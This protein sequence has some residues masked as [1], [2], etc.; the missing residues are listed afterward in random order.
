M[1]VVQ[2]E[3]LLTDFQPAKTSF[4]AAFVFT[5]LHV[6]QDARPELSPK[7][8]VAKFEAWRIGK[9]KVSIDGLDDKLRA[10]YVTYCDGEDGYDVWSHNNAWA[11]QKHWKY[12]TEGE[13]EMN[14]GKTFHF[15]SM[16]HRGYFDHHSNDS[17]LQYL[18]FVLTK[19]DAALDACNLTNAVVRIGKPKNNRSAYKTE[20]VFP[21]FTFQEFLTQA[22][23]LDKQI[24]FSKINKI[25]T[26][27]FN[28]Y[29]N[30]FIFPLI[31]EQTDVVI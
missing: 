29:F 31:K 15:H 20:Y 11:K 6:I 16:W 9:K 10:S 14:D 7:E 12:H 2:Y 1:T 24:D 5:I 22:R 27:D 3:H 18:L 8:V 23:W 26:K 19:D 17:A 13:R 21:S 28:R 4:E 30:D 25:G